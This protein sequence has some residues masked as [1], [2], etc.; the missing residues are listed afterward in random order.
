MPYVAL[1]FPR[2]DQTMKLDSSADKRF[3]FRGGVLS[4]ACLKGR[5][6][7]IRS[8][9]DISQIS[10]VDVRGQRCWLYVLVDSVGD[11]QL[12]IALFNALQEIGSFLHVPATPVALFEAPPAPS[13]MRF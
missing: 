5:K 6:T 11:A 10:G 13:F 7:L 4:G 2:L 9:C 12:M 8:N 1:H 3:G